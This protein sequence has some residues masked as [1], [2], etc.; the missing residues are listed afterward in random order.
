LAAQ[1]VQNI[2]SV[3][4]ANDRVEQLNG[5]V[6]YIE[7]YAQVITLEVPD[8]LN[9]FVM[10]ETLN[11][12]ELRTTQADLVKNFLLGESSPERTEEARKEWATMEGIL[13]TLEQDGLALT[14]LRHLLISMYG[15]TTEREVLQKIRDHASGKQNAIDFLD[16][17]AEHAANYVAIVTPTHAKWNGYPRDIRRHILTLGILQLTPLKPLMLAVAKHFPRRQAEKAYSQFVSWSV[18]F[19]IAGGGRSGTVEQAFAR[20]AADVSNGNI[21]SSNALASNMAKVVP[22]DLEFEAAF[23]RARVSKH[24]LAR[25]Y[26]RELELKLRGDSEPELV[27]ND[28]IVINLEHILPDKPG[29]NW[30]SFDASSSSTYHSRLGNMVL[31]KSKINSKI[32][33]KSFAEKRKTLRDTEFLLTKDVANKRIWNSKSIEDRQARLAAQAV[34]IWPVRAP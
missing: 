5:W 21:R 7:K 19:L 1:Y 27:P 12:R 32:G 17:I 24:A 16:A 2:I 14:Y 31:L 3:R 6:N 15:P 20:A 8:H 9:A 22:T 18:R 34:S 13:D 11:D 10:F 33:N 23:A 26:L 4:R 29:N 28:D 25:Y 30:P